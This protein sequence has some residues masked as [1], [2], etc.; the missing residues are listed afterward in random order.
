MKV[1]YCGRDEDAFRDDPPRDVGIPPQSTT[2]ALTA[3][4]RLDGLS[5]RRVGFH[6]LLEQ[7]DII[8]LHIPL[9]AVSRHL[10]NRAALA[11]MKPTAYLINTSRGEIVDEAAL[12]EALESG[13]IAGAG[14]DVY[15]QE[16]AVSPP[17]LKMPNVV[18]LP[19]IGS[20]TTETRTAMAML[21]VENVIDLF[22]GQ[23]PRNAI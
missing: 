8:T 10:I 14:L 20:A 13:R 21:A 18:L 2:S 23:T 3:S 1:L 7:A 19:H 6:K 4:A 11:H 22:S 12:V 5:A 15:E 16:P 17:L 9:A